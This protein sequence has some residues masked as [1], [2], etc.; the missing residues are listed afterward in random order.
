M[1]EMIRQACDNIHD[2]LLHQYSG[3]AKMSSLITDAI[4]CFLGTNKVAGKSVS[5]DDMDSFLEALNTAL[6]NDDRFGVLE[7]GWPLSDD[8]EA[9]VIRVKY[10]V[11]LTN[12]D[13][14]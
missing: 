3:G 8:K 10:F 9:P 13:G 2:S 7:Y 4:Y 1:K 11:Y 5:V 6:K 12:E 14:G